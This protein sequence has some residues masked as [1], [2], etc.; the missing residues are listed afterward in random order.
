MREM[1]MHENGWRYDE[2]NVV[3]DHT[4]HLAVN[5]SALGIHDGPLSIVQ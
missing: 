5:G 4:H 1:Q 3:E 2:V